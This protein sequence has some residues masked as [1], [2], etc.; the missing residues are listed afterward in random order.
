MIIEKAERILENHELCNNCL[1]RCFAKLGKGKNSERGKAIRN[2]LNMEREAN[3][4][5]PI[6]EPQTCELCGNIFKKRDYF[7][8]KCYDKALKL[9]LEFDSFL[10]GSSFPKD[11]REKERAI[12]EEFELDYAEPINREFNREVG[13]ALEL[14]FQKPVNKKKCIFTVLRAVYILK[15][16]LLS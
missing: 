5:P 3:K 12:V 11:V 7:A 10:V 4:Q 9:G 13:K 15:T 16:K 8:Q 6:K 14:L 1:G 2:V